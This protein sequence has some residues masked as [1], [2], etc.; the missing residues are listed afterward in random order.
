MDETVYRHPPE[1]NSPPIATNRCRQQYAPRGKSRKIGSKAIILPS[2]VPSTTSYLQPVCDD[3][4]SNKHDLSIPYLEQHRLQQEISRRVVPHRQAP[5]S[6][7]GT[8]SDVKLCTRDDP[9]RRKPRRATRPDCYEVK[10][11][12]EQARAKQKRGHRRRSR[13]EQREHV[14][15]SADRTKTSLALKGQSGK[16]RLTVRAVMKFQ[17]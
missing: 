16:S 3:P 6:S 14:D 11:R 15:K 2:R 9:Y 10:P 1:S 4:A 8:A 7:P 13:Q 5:S 17:P 12:K